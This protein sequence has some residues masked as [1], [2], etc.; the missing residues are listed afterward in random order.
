MRRAGVLA[1]LGALALAACSPGDETFRAPSESMVPTIGVGEEFTVDTSAYDEQDPRVGDVV[2]IRAP[3]SAVDAEGT[4]RGDEADSV[5]RLCGQ[6]AG[7][8]DEEV[9]FVERVVAGPGQRVRV[10]GGR[11]ILD[12]RE[13]AEPYVRACGPAATQCDFPNEI[14]VPDGHYYVM[15]D[16][17]GR[18]LDSRFWGAVPRDAFVGR[19]DDPRP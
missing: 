10:R 13:Q 4:C 15:G 7:P 14:T 17:R 11:V 6:P 5:E 18:S 16:N 9:R 12:G 3:R 8:L 2:V 19:V 1:A